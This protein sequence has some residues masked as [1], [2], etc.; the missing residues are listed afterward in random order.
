MSDSPLP[1]LLVIEDSD[2][3][4]AVLKRILEQIVEQDSLLCRIDRCMTGDEALEYL[5]GKASSASET[6][7]ARLPSL[8]LLDLLLPGIDGAEVLRQVKQSDRLRS[9]PIVVLGGNMNQREI[10]SLYEQ[11]ISGYIVKRVDGTKFRRNMQLFIEY[12]LIANRLP[13]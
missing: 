2:E 6:D 12:W 1:L 8:I 10:N 9:I 3:D 4:F 11:G 7:L 5:L 13:T